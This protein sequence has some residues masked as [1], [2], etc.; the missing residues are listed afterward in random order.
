MNVIFQ[1]LMTHRTNCV[2]KTGHMQDTRHVSFY[3][4]DCDF[5]LYY[6]LVLYSLIIICICTHNFLSEL[7]AMR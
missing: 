1:R 7:F 6:T 2:S 5:Y 3:M 4:Y